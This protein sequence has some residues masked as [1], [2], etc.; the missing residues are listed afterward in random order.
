MECIKQ[1]EGVL[2]YQNNPLCIHHGV[3]LDCRE[4]ELQPR[5]WLLQARGDQIQSRRSKPCLAVIDSQEEMHQLSCKS[6]ELKIY[7][8]E[9]QHER[10]RIHIRVLGERLDSPSLQLKPFWK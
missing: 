7:L 3:L 4:H 1:G 5:L 2:K 9:L 6:L 8:L 10:S